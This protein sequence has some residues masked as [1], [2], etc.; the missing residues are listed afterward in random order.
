MHLARALLRR[1]SMNNKQGPLL[2]GRI[3]AAAIFLVAGFSKVIAWNATL[4]SMSANGVPHSSLLLTFAAGVE[5]VGGLCLLL[6]YRTRAFAWILFVYLIPVSLKFH[7]FWRFS[8]FDAQMQLMNFLKNL[9]IMG[10][11]LAYATFGA[12]ALSLDATIRKRG[13]SLAPGKVHPSE[14]PSSR[15]TA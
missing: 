11:L 10:G 6:G 14:P 15:M 7:A 9:A 13:R 12:G 2:A 4:D 3:L 8:G 5:I 1:E